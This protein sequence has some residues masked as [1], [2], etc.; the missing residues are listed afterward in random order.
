MEGMKMY[1]ITKFFIG[2]LLD[3][4]TYIEKT[5]MQFYLNQV[6]ANPCGG[7]PYKIISI[8]TL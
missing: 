8:R 3:G 2:G 1:E 7:S 4:L 5:N 6:V